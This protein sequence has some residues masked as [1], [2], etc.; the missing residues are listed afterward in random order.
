[1]KKLNWQL[2]YANLL[3]MRNTSIS[4]HN[5]LVMFVVSISLY[6][7]SLVESSKHRILYYCAMASMIDYIVRVVAV[8][9]GLFFVICHLTVIHVPCVGH[10]YTVGLN[11]WN[12][13]PCTSY[14]YSLFF[15]VYC[16]VVA[17]SSHIFTVK[18]A[19]EE[20]DA[21]TFF[22]VNNS[23]Y[24][25]EEDRLNKRRLLQFLNHVR[26]SLL[27]ELMSTCHLP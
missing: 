15:V 14:H 10:D 24:G 25:S 19:S 18:E 27:S 23:R 12:T 13:L 16:I 26:R 21:R 9:S 1:M 11:I 8:A 5:T 17:S 4:L 22:V 3:I 20:E 6:Y 2:D 7:D